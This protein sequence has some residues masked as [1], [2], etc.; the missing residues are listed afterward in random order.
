MEESKW[1]QIEAPHNPYA[2]SGIPLWR[3][4]VGNA[5]WLIVSGSGAITYIEERTRFSAWHPKII[6]NEN[7]TANQETILSLALQNTDY[8]AFER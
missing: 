1:E 8:K 2:G 4:K 5:G 6:P 7:Q 3:Q